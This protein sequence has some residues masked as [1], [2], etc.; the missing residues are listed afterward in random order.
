MKHET[1]LA[2]QEIIA[3]MSRA[4][5]VLSSRDILHKEI[6]ESLQKAQKELVNALASEVTDPYVPLVGTVLKFN[7]KTN[8]YEIQ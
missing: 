4:I 8:Q 7:D 5:M 1:A 6:N 2:L 3:V